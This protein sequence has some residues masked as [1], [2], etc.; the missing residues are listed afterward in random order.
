MFKNPIDQQV[1]NLARQLYPEKP[2]HLLH[3]FQDATVKPYGYLVIDLKPTTPDSLR[4][5]KNVL[6]I[7]E[8]LEHR[9]VLVSQR[10]SQIGS[11]CVET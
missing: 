10:S 11:C 5:R 7:R 6:E 4:L 3:H 8:P 1:M 2:N 9:S